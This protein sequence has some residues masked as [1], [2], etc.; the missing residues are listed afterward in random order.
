MRQ[1]SLRARLSKR[2]DAAARCGA[3]K[4]PPLI[5]LHG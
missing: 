4:S 2:A 5:N 3:K 1:A